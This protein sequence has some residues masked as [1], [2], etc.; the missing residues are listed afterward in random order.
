MRSVWVN[1][2]EIAQALFPVLKRDDMEFPTD[3]FFLDTI[4][5]S[6]P[7]TRPVSQFYLVLF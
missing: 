6:P 1:E 3:L 7:C 5:V 2:Q 4:P